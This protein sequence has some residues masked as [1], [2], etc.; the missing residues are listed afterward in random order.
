[1]D[2]PVEPHCAH[3]PNAS[4]IVGMS[5]HN[6]DAGKE[7]GV[8]DAPAGKGHSKTPNQELTLG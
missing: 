2:A 4:S 3:G 5:S 7:G 8:T 1:M 6:R